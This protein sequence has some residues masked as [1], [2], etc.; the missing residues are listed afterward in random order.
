M[1]K[2][3]KLKVGL[4][5]IILPK[6]GWRWLLAISSLPSLI[7]TIACFKLTESVHYEVASGNNEEA[8]RTLKKI[9]LANNI[10]MPKGTLI[11]RSLV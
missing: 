7:A 1:K 10:R 3:L 5:I 4:S 11:Q 6:I 9:A 8:V 2:Y